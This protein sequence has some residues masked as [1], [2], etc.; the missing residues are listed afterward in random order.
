MPGIYPTLFSGSGGISSAAVPDPYVPVDGTM[1]VTGNVN[2]SLDF[3]LPTSG[4]G[5]IISTGNRALAFNGASSNGIVLHSDT[6]DGANIAI[7]LAASNDLT[8][9]SAKILS[10]GDN[11]GTSYAEKA[12]VDKDGLGDFSGGATFGGSTTT[13]VLIGTNGTIAAPNAASQT[14]IYYYTNGAGSTYGFGSSGGQAGIFGGNALVG[15][16]AGAEGFRAPKAFGVGGITAV[17][18]AAYTATTSDNLVLTDPNAAAGSF[19]VT[20]PAANGFGVGQLLTVKVT[21]THAS[22]VVTVIRAGADTIEG[23]T[24]GQTTTTFTTTANLASA[25]FQSDGTSKW[26]LIASNGTV[27]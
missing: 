26:Y 11:A 1:N 10:I 3:A 24:A 23:V 21:A 12:Y 19:A 5:I 16:T 25:T 13:E 4:K 17:K 20:L 9:A 14:G 15:V 18:S 27:T 6:A 8:N 22:R 2:T 7:R